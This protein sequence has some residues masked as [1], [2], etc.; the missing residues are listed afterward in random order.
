MYINLT[1]NRIKK[2]RNYG[3]DIPDS[4]SH[5]SSDFRCEIPASIKNT[6]IGPKVKLG[7][8]SYAV[9]GYI[10]AANIGRYCSFGEDIQI[11]RQNHP[12]DWLSTSPHF[13]LPAE[14]VQDMPPTIKAQSS[15][16]YYPHGK[17]PTVMK[18]TNIGHDVWIGHG[19]Y[20]K[21]GITV[22]TG[23]IVAAMSVV[24]KDLPP[25]AIV[26]GNPAKLIRYRFSKNIIEKLLVSEWWEY[27]PKSLRQF[28]LHNVE[29]LLEGNKIESLKK[30]EFKE[31]HLATFKF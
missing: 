28:Q 10:M 27:T 12:I 7:A 14:Q 16:G 3:F 11:G 8:Y 25:Y 31:L 15:S 18:V 30:N 5:I 24:T 2:L 4:H 22:G 6:V 20:I 13:Y 17:A 23:A 9:S 19:A 29:D 21:P 1:K 26:G